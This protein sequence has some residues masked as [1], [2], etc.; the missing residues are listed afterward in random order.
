MS[1]FQEFLATK[2]IDAATF[3]KAESEK[4]TEWE[5]LFNQV[6]PKSFVAQKLFLINPIRRKYPLSKPQENIP[7]KNI[8]KARPNFKKNA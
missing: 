3:E 8:K 6:N 1:E 2:K 7:Q 5:R 4:F